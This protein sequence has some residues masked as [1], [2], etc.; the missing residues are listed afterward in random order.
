MAG[1]EL[2]LKLAAC[3]VETSLAMVEKAAVAQERDPEA[4]G[5]RGEDDP[6]GPAA[7]SRREDQSQVDRISHAGAADPADW[8]RGGAT[9]VKPK[10]VS[11]LRREKNDG[12]TGVHE[13]ERS[14]GALPRLKCNLHERKVNLD[15]IGEGRTRCGRCSLVGQSQG[16]ARQ[17]TRAL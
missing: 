13:G 6:R 17:G 1:L 4:I 8:S 10:H 2:D 15:L 12:T 3:S 16:Y 5:L 9:P 14:Y 11:I 7:P